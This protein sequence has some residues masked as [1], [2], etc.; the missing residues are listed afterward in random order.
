MDLI[1]FFYKFCRKDGAQLSTVANIFG[2]WLLI[3]SLNKGVGGA[4]LVTGAAQVFAMIV[5]LAYYLCEKGKLRFQNLRLIFIFIV[6]LCF[7]VYRGCRGIYLSCPYIWK[8][9]VGARFFIWDAKEN[10]RTKK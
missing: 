9:F 3:Y 2:D 1:L 7:V 6:K 10:G 8:I 4:A 5:L